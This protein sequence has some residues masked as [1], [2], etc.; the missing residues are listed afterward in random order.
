[1]TT[2]DLG[3]S[4][5][6]SVSRSFYLTIRLLPTRLREPIGLAY[7]LARAS[8]TVA[9]S[10]DASAAERRGHLAALARMI[11][12]GE[13]EGLAALQ[14]DIR[15]NHSGEMELISKLDRCL[16][17]LA[18][19]QDFDREQIRVVMARIIRG[20]DLDLARFGDAREVI[21]LSTAED[22]EEYTYLVAGCVGEFWT[23]LCLHHLPRYSR[24]AVEPLRALGI[25]YGKGLQLVNILRDMPADLRSGRCYLPTSEVEAATVVANPATAAEA[26]RRWQCRARTLLTAGRQYIESLRPARLRA[27]VYL[28]WNLGLKT[29]DLIAARPPLETTE[30]VKVTRATVRKALAQAVL[31][32]FSNWPLRQ[33]PSDSNVPS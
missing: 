24:L 16:D 2:I 22:L 4:L 8:D 29:L 30:R 1:M 13:R 17:W 18:G 28:P 10:A 32:S 31:V 7:L 9:D 15:S 6:K 21:G 25:D 14:R 19:Q 11:Q 33:R 3:G 12:H 23:D 20:Q 5:L 26:C 27:A